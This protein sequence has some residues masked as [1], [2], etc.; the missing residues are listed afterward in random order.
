MH[1]KTFALAATNSSKPYHIH[2]DL[3]KAKCESVFV[4]ATYDSIKCR[5]GLYKFRDV[6]E[7]TL[8]LFIQWAYTGNYV[9]EA[10]A[11][12]PVIPATPTADSLDTNPVIP[13]VRVHLFAD[14]YRIKELGEVA[15]A[16]VKNV[17]A[18][19]DT[20]TIG[21]ISWKQA[22]EILDLAFGNLEAHDPL[23]A[24]LGKYTARNIGEFRKHDA[25]FDIL[26]KMG[27]ALMEY[28][29]PYEGDPYE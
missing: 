8:G 11:N 14:T 6:D 13:H 21:M 19:G 2:L 25:F 18:G 17:F 3:L 9:S 29:L 22:F 20:D 28:V 26:P 1:S 16:K 4:D 7:A 15:L 10:P 5:T 24:F 27:R 12:N 23:L